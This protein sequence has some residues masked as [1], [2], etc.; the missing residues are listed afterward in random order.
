MSVI[1]ATL[2]AGGSVHEHSEYLDFEVVVGLGRASFRFC[3]KTVVRS[4]DKRGLGAPPLQLKPVAGVLITHPSR[5]RRMNKF[6][7][8]EAMKSESGD[9][10]LPKPRID[11]LFLR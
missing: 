5:W 4:S 9:W 7:P 8:M 10:S 11:L 6:L 3:S 1:L 2:H